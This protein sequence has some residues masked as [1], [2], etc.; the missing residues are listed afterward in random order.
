MS[1]T[2]AEKQP[3]AHKQD[4]DAESHSVQLKYQQ[5]QSI[6]ASVTQQS[7]QHWTTDISVCDERAKG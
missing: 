6:R 4:G 3:H 5:N 7:Q 1:T 2:V